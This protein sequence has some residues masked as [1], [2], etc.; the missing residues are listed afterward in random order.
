MTPPSPRDEGQA[1]RDLL[2]SAFEH[3]PTGM[4]V[5]T[6]TGVL[7]ACNPTLASLLGRSA[8][9][10]VGRTLFEVTHP[11]ALPQAQATCSGLRQADASTARHES[12]F[13]RPDGTVVEVLVTTS[14]VPDASGSPA[15]LVMHI[16]DIG[17][18][19][20]QEAEIVHRALH[21][22]LTGLPNRTLLHDRIEHALARTDRFP[23]PVCLFLLD[24]DGFKQ[25]NDRY[26]HLAGDELLQQFAQ[27]LT[28]LL[29]P[30]DTAARLGGDE[31]VVLCE[32]TEPARAV[33][34][35]DRLRAAAGWPFEVAGAQVVVGA[36]VGV[37]T[38]E[39][40][41]GPA[42]DSPELL[43]RAD[44]A[45]YDDKRRSRAAGPRPSPGP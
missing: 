34:I 37:S 11:D 30:G 39:S 10:L 28:A 17:E 7:S 4:A 44:A 27:R 25:V 43:R 18:R 21:D 45:M 23:S 5:A 22:P 38:S 13:V 31:F 32:D 12:R 16:E 19:K 2:L 14:R 41:G 42:L 15:H 9:E 33:A 6:P 20:A 40:A 8:T 1:P 29:R 3:A 24:L 35:A 36:S 26:G